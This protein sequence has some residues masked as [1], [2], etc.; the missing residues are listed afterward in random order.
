MDV[1]NFCSMLLPG[2]LPLRLGFALNQAI[3]LDL[4]N[5]RVEVV[6]TLHLKFEERNADGER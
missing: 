5:D 1:Y 3:E 4:K 2:K 6:L